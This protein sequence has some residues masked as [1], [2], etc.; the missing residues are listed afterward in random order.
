MYDI[1]EFSKKRF[2]LNRWQ[3]LEIS[4]FI[5]FL[6]TRKNLSNVNLKIIDKDSFIRFGLYN[7]KPL[8][9]TLSKSLI[10]YVD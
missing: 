8:Y 9:K 1:S 10:A 4:K 2:K 6:N 5:Y 3:R 7:K